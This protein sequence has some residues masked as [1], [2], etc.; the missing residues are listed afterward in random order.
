MTPTDIDWLDIELAFRDTTRTESFLDRESGEVL[1]VVPGFSDESELRAAIGRA[2]G[3]YVALVP[4]T[5]AYARG[6]MQRFLER[7][8]AGATRRR[9]LALQHKT[10]A[11]TRSLGLL[12]QHPALLEDFH[13]FEQMAFWE[14]VERE[15]S[16][17]GIHATSRPPSVELF[18]GPSQREPRM[19]VG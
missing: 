18:E 15:L 4:V 6:V 3:R 1:S 10:G 13:R 17:A 8:P 11:Y 12:E 5:T 7:L 16:A 2:P 19:R 14:H 9:L